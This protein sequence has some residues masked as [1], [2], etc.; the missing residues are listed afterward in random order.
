MIQIFTYNNTFGGFLTVVF[1]C[2]RRGAYP[3]DIRPEARMQR[4][5]FG[6]HI[7]I[8][9]DPGK[10]ERVW[11]GLREKISGKSR[12]LPFYAFLSEAEGI[13]MKLYRFIRRVF[14]EHFNVETDFGDPDVLFLNQMARKVK[15]EAMRMMQFVRFQ[16]AK[17]GLY[18]CGIEP[19]Y[20]VIPLVINHYKKRFPGQKWIIYDL[21]RDYGIFYNLKEFQELTIAK[22]EFDT[23]NGA[24]KDEVLNEEEA[25][26]QNLWR[27]YFRNI[28]IKER[29]NLRLQRQHMPQRFWRFLPEMQG[30]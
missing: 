23:L 29:K 22:K 3:A 4:N 12:D 26:Y 2:Y 10:A 25:F 20:D 18:F 7:F 16:R 6:E 27:V 1:E 17:D 9:S 19:Q 13:E 14:S 21:K 30:Q 11:R 28:N 15:R 8:G 5:V 24:L